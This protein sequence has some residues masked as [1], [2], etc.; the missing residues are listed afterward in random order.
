MSSQAVLFRH[1]KNLA[2]EDCAFFYHLR[3]MQRS[4]AELIEIAEREQNPEY[5][6]HLVT[7]DDCRMHVQERDPSSSEEDK[8][9]VLCAAINRIEQIIER[10]NE[11]RDLRIQRNLARAQAR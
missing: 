1:K 11:I 2:S 3:K 8:V 10:E 4:L 7:C 5:L 6:Y 9:V